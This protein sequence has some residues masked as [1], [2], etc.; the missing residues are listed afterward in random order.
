MNGDLILEYIRHVLGIH[1]DYKSDAPKSLPGF[2][3]T[4]YRVQRITLDGKAAVFVYPKI[5]L[6]SISTVQKHIERIE[7]RENLP[8]VL[9]LD[10]L[11]SRQKEYLLKARIPFVVDGKQIYLPFMAVY[12]QE[13]GDREEKELTHL[14]PSAQLLL[15]HYIYNGCGEMLTKEATD[16]LGFTPTSISRASR[17]LEE[18]GFIKGEKRGVQKVISSPFTPRELFFMARGSMRSPN[19]RTVYVPCGKVNETLLLSGYSALAEYT[20]LNPPAVKCFASDSIVEWEKVST[21]KLQNADDQYEIQL[22]RYDPCKLSFNGQVDS[23]SLALA[24]SEDKDE[25][26]EAAVEDMLLKTWVAIDGKRA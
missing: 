9:I 11:S 23:L 7:E 18:L 26:V 20:M 5:E 12:L 21:H 10:R 17:Q 13:R 3:Q 8:A 25:R 24:L 4:R 22:W 15:L 14:L 19:K 6:D 1:V 2:L 16:A